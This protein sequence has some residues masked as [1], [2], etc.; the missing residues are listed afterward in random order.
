MLDLRLI[1][2]EVLKLR[3]RRGMLVLAALLTLG[4]ALL[5]FAVAGI[6]HTGDPARYRPAGG[7]IGYDDTAFVL[8]MMA[9]VIGVIVGGTAGTQDIESGVFRDL[10]ATGRSRLALFAARVTGAWVVVLSILAVTMAATAVLSMAMADSAV[11][12]DAG[13]IAARTAGVLVAGALSSALAVGLSALVGSRGPVIG[14]LLAFFL[15]VQL[16]LLNVAFLGA[17][18]QGIP[19]VAIDRIADVQVRGGVHVALGTAIIAVIAWGGSALGLGAW[20]TKTRE[21]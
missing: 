10:A 3:R 4:V 18:R 13:M 14:V 11:A 7:V 2:A 1:S 9:T 16:L 21:I 5:M 6:Q 20:K 8:T 12:P 17:A 15:V 19:A